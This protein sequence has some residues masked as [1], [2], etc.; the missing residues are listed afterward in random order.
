[1]QNKNNKEI[2][3]FINNNYYNLKKYKD[4]KLKRFIILNDNLLTLK[5][6]NQNKI[7]HYCIEKQNFE[8]SKI[9]LNQ[10]EKILYEKN[11]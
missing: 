10:N 8:I 11:S 9:I 5:D 1:M 6:E 4:N 2:E 7:M 3:T